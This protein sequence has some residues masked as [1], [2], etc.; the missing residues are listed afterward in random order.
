MGAFPCTAL[1]SVLLQ[2]VVEPL[3]APQFSCSGM[4][5]VQHCM[6]FSR[7]DSPPQKLLLACRGFLYLLDARDAA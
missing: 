1:R 3:R 4:L 7:M 6:R 2:L 5:P